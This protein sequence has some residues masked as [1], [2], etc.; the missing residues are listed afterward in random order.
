MQLAGTEIS[1]RTLLH[2]AM[3]NLRPRKRAQMR[4]VMVREHFNMGSTAAY[5]LCREF[6]MDPE[7]TVSP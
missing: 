3:R 7:E 5:A 4:W 1:E 6:K 2:H